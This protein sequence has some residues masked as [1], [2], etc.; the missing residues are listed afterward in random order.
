MSSKGEWNISWSNGGHK[1]DVHLTGTVTFTDDLTDVQTLSD[2]G[3]L[4]LRR[5]DE[6]YR[7]RP[8]PDAGQRC[9]FL[10]WRMPQP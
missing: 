3:S 4:T 2:G 6:V 10:V 5:D 8:Y 9:V 7:S 1:L